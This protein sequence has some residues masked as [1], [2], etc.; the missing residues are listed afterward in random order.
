MVTMTILLSR[1]NPSLFHRLD[2]P[3]GHAVIVGEY[4]VDVFIHIQKLN[5]KFVPFGAEKVT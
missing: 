5:S 1:T 3:K 4:H 2:R